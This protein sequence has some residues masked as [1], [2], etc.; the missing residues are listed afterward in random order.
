ML[1]SLLNGSDNH[2][3]IGIKKQAAFEEVINL[4]PV[5]KKLFLYTIKNVVSTRLLETC[6]LVEFVS[7]SF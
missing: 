5:Y 7:Y 2:S 1:D 6:L 4:S 3:D